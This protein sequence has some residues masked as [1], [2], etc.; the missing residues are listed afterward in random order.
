MKRHIGKLILAHVLALLTLALLPLSGLAEERI[1]EFVVSARMEK[2][3]T[4]LVRERIKVNIE[5]DVIKRGIYRV[6]RT[7]QRLDSGK[8]RHHEVSI[9]SVTLDGK[10]VPY[11]T[12]N[13]D[14]HKAVVIGDEQAMAPL[15][16]HDYVIIYNT[17]NHVR[18]FDDRDEI[19]LNVTGNE[20]KLPIDKAI[21][22]L[23]M[24][25]GGDDITKTAAFTGKFGERGSDAVITQGKNKDYIFYTTRRLEPGEGLTV[26]AAWTKGLVDQPE[27]TFTQ[28]VNQNR[29]LSYLG[30]FGYLVLFCFLCRLWLGRT[31]RPTIIPLFSAPVGMSPGY[32]AALKDRSYTGR[33]LHGDIL[34]AA[35]N[36]YLHMD[37]TDKKN[38]VMRTRKPAKK[39]D[40]WV[41]HLC[42]PFVQLLC[43][44]KGCNLKTAS[45]REKARSAFESQVYTYHEEQKEL[46]KDT[47]IYKI[48]AWFSIST[49]IFFVTLFTDSPAYRESLFGEMEFLG[50]TGGGFVIIAISYFAAIKNWHEHEGFTR[51]WKM[52]LA[53]GG[54]LPLGFFVLWV[55]A[56]EDY[57]LIAMLG[58]LAIA[59]TVLLK[60]L[61]GGKYTKEGLAE[62]VQM[63]GLE[64]YICTAEKHRLAKINAPDDTVQKY[65]ELL[66][67]AVALGH[68][69][70]WQKRFDSLLHE[71]DYAP[72][73]IEAPTLDRDET[74]DYRTVVSTVTTSAAM[75]VAVAACAATS[76]AAA[77]AN[78]AHSDSSGSS[79]YSSGS[80]FSSSDSDGGSSGGGSGGGGGGGW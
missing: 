9:V 68:A 18:F 52:G 47:L 16:E 58:G 29:E 7:T 44:S 62:Y 26:A 34:W 42:E 41:Q 13:R 22:S 56:E 19:Y 45:G 65:E 69:A 78:K 5:H 11:T 35:V 6:F 14:S 39:P 61:P 75:S 48:F 72:E 36:G 79:G 63:K 54:L 55:T 32:M 43:G 15:G 67:Y 17:T 21:F 23:R 28:R 57:A 74:Y 50:V 30:V 49:L 2:D 20:W 80:G 40:L 3:S 46:W 64:M 66:P 77:I 1:M 38:I 76:Q 27:P 73:W 70:A 59:T 71:M 37:M 51:I 8:Y 25:G 4:M 12:A 53:L 31:P 24:P 10:K 60:R 33:V